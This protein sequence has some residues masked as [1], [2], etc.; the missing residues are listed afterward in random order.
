MI[1]MCPGF[2]L[3]SN[4]EFAHSFVIGHELAHSID[5]CTIAYAPI[6]WRTAAMYPASQEQLPYK[7]LVTCLRSKESA[8]ARRSNQAD[9]DVL[10]NSPEDPAARKMTLSQQFCEHDEIRETFSDFMGLEAS[11]CAV[12]ALN[13]D[14]LPSQRTEGVRN[15]GRYFCEGEASPSR[16]SVEDTSGSTH[17]RA[18]ERINRIMAIHPTVR[19]REWLD[20]GPAA[21]GRIYCGSSSQLSTPAVVTPIS[22]PQ[23]LKGTR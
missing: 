18:T 20:C 13:P 10:A 14:I 19:S 5:P 8:E 12:T 17:S 2:N 16:K 4:S 11:L 1:K 22:P 15:I 23:P 3:T 6:N 7:E 21:P 9:H